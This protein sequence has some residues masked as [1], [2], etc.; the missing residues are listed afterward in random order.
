[1]ENWNKVM[2]MLGRRP[3]PSRL[4]PTSERIEAF[5]RE[6]GIELP[7]D[8]R[9]FLAEHGGV[10]VSALA[11][12]V[13]PTP[14]GQNATIESFYGFIDGKPKS[15]DLRIQCNLAEGAPVAIPIAGGAFGS[16]VFLFTS[17]RE[18]LGIDHGAIYFWDCD[19]RSAWRDEMFHKNFPNMAPGLKHY[20]ELRRDNKLPSKDDAMRDFYRIAASFTDFLTACSRWVN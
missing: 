12:I 18:R 10:W 17:N 15:C 13:E 9:T 1:M 5:E 8:Y 14:C 7:Q 2:E 20:I 16:Q 3:I 11:P 19:N 6:F 4:E